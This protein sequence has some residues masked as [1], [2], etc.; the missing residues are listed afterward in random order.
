M[1]KK[2]KSL[3]VIVRWRILFALIIAM[4]FFAYELNIKKTIAV[5]NTYKRLKTAADTIQSD[6]TFLKNAKDKTWAIP[7]DTDI[8]Q[9]LKTQTLLNYLSKYC[10][11][12]DLEIKQIIQ[13]F[14]T[15]VHDYTIETNKVVVAGQY[16]NTLN[17]IYKLEH[18]KKIAAIYAA[19]WELS[20]DRTNETYSLLTTL[21]IK[22]IHYESK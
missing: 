5:V 20:K 3:S 6:I 22:H 4:F 16:S 2:I 9:S 14:Y 10:D 13:S 19:H 21:Y 12:N 7:Y 11:S 8:N 15:K 17:L 1:L 18:E